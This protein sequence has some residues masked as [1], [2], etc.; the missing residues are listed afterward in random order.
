MQPW[1]ATRTRFRERV[2]EDD[3][4]VFRGFCPSKLYPRGSNI[5]IAGDP[6]SE[7]H[8]IEQGQVKLVLPTMDGKDRILAVCG[9]DN[10]IG[11]AFLGE[12]AQYRVDAVALT[13]V[14]TCAMSRDQFVQ[15]VDRAPT[16]ALTI[17]EIL[18]EHLI[19]CRSLLAGSYDPINLGC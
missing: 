1:F 11:E 6:A 10:F 7:L 19:F 3:L 4:E 9:P 18:A 17:S 8:I 14:Y 13:D 16:F 15:I 2:D 5:F 12:D